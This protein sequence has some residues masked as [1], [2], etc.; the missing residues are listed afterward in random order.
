M[1]PRHKCQL[2]ITIGIVRRLE[3]ECVCGRAAGR[4]AHLQEQEA[5]CSK[6]SLGGWGMDEPTF[7]LIRTTEHGIVCCCLNNVYRI[8][9]KGSFLISVY[10]PLEV[11]LT[12]Y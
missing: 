4:S 3:T 11:F 9:I 1:F 8:T 10:P 12:Y 2:S 6:K 5:L 7:L